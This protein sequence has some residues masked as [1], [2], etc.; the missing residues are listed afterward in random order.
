MDYLH[1]LVRGSTEAVHSS[2]PVDVLLWAVCFIKIDDRNFRRI[3]GFVGLASLA[4]FLI[5]PNYE[6]RYYGLFFIFTA[7]AVRLIVDSRA[8][9]QHLAPR[10]E[11]R[12]LAN[13]VLDWF[14]K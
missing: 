3:L 5:F 10:T 7:A 8:R 4:H 2:A 13:G 12:A 6:P 1:A 11:G 9:N 14:P